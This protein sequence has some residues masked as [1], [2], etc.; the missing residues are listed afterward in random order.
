MSGLSQNVFES[1]DGGVFVNLRDGA[2][3]NLTSTLVS[4]KQGLDVNVINSFQVG[5]A[6]QSAFTYGA[7]LYEPVGGVYN[8]SITQLTSGQSGAFSV[9][10]YRDL[11][12]NLRNSSGS[13]MGNSN[14]NGLFVRPGDGTNSQAYAASGEA[15]ATIREGGNVANV[16]AGNELKVIDTNSGSIL[17]LMTP[18]SAA[19]SSVAVVATAG[20]GVL[21][22]ANPA[23]KGFSAQNDTNRTIYIA[24]AATA[25]VTAY[26]VRLAVNGYYEQLGGGGV[27]TGDISVIGAGGVTGNAIVTEYT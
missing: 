23:R 20:G 4:G 7:S 11:R 12:V 6:D 19:L 9:T 14:A 5:I 10:S 27:Y 26:T 18:A 13:E 2:G 21:L 24:M 3:T 8:S 25:D 15:F 17:S 16:T 1:A 22:A